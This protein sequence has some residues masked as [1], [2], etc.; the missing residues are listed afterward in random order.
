MKL[1]TIIT[2]I[3]L[4]FTGIGSAYS[5]SPSS[6]SSYKNL[7]DVNGYRQGH[8]VITGEM[9]RE[10]GYN[11][12]QIVEEGVYM[13]NKRQGLWKK[14]FPTGALKSEITYSDNHP[15]GSYKVYYS[16]GQVEEE[17][18]WLVNRNTGDFKRYHENGELAQEFHFNTAGKRHGEQ[19]YF[20]ENGKVVLSVELYNG[21]VHGIYKTY[22]ADGSIR[23]EK[24]ITNGVVE[25]ES[26]VTFPP[27][28]RN[29]DHA[30]TPDLPRNETKPVESDKPNLV[31]FD[32]NGSNTLYNKDK[33]VTQVGKF[34][35]GRLWDGKWYRYDENG[36]L[37]RVEVYK[38]GRFIGYGIIDDAN[39]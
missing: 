5:T 8:W 28:K 20:G 35:N 37:R 26:L 31:A 27:Q 22:Y 11:K 19:K 12:N 29:T 7:T 30:E 36:L 16:T 18:Y 1:Q 6:D 15:L 9:S 39:N 23:E 25:K 34:N 24:R 2:Y 32:S 14:Y 13:D 17:G 38:E 33:Q 21:V 10:E 3:F 4:I